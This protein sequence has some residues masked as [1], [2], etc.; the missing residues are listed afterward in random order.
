MRAEVDVPSVESLM[1]SPLSKFIHFAANDCGYSGTMHELIASWVHPLFLKTKT[2]A[3]KQ[4]NPNWR[5]AMNGPFRE[6]YWTAACKEIE[7]LEG[8]D[9][10]DVVDRSEDMNVIDSIWAFKLK[11]FPDGMIKKF[12]A[13]FCARGDQ[14]LEEIDFFGTYAL[15]V[16]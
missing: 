4:D 16:Q 11:R 2:E 8:I 12:K 13:Q 9:A 6:E 3:S 15:V 14:Q 10:W 7:I 1:A 5:S